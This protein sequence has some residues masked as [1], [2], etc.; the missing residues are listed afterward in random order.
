MAKTYETVV[1]SG[2]NFEIIFCSGDRD[3]K[4]FKVSLDTYDFHNNVIKIAIINLTVIIGFH[5]PA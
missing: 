3:E 4:S 2:K 5:D 1:K